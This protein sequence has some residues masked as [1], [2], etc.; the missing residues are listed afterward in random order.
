MKKNILALSL[1]LST[2]AFSTTTLVSETPFTD[3]PKNHWAYEAIESGR[4]EGLWVG[5]KEGSFGLTQDITRGEFSVLI[6]RDIEWLLKQ[7]GLKGNEIAFEATKHTPPLPFKD[8]TPDHWA[9]EAI[10]TGFFSGLWKGYNLDTFGPEKPIT[11]AEVSVIV[12]RT[13]EIV[14]PWF[15]A[16]SDD[17]ERV[18][19]G[20][21]FI[22]SDLNTD[23]WAKESIIEGYELGL[24]EGYE[25]GS[26]GINESITREEI[27]I[28]TYR[29]NQIVKNWL[30]KNPLDS[31]SES[32]IEAGIYF[33]ETS[34]EEL[35]YFYTFPEK[36]DDLKGI[37]IYMHG[38]GGG[39]EQGMSDENY[40]GN[41]KTLKTVLSDANILYATPETSNFGEIGGAELIDFMGHLRWTYGDTIPIYLSGASAGGRTIFE[42]LS[43]QSIEDL[44]VDGAVFMVPA[45]S[46]SNIKALNF[47]PTSL[48][49]WIESGEN[50]G[51]FPADEATLFEATLLDKGYETVLNIIPNGDHNAPVEQIEWEV[52]L[53]FLTD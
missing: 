2:I 53:N 33:S 51:V 1:I 37:F 22:F 26:F 18:N 10:T 40:A 48:K 6:N 14:M 13:I 41:F 29:L 25:N 39:Y 11:R 46:S 43:H 3:V 12:S 47:G 16:T 9:Y 31:V 50:D 23:H 36:G 7:G 30:S 5:Y 17:L 44:N 49:V 35:P 38:A 20:D 32:T 24:W 45:I 27:A 21:N 19:S 8:V 52:V 28:V 42:T 15:N 34:Q 4:N